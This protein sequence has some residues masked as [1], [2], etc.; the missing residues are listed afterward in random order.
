MSSKESNE[1]TN[2]TRAPEKTPSRYVQ[3]KHPKYQ[4]LCGKESEIQ[5]RRTLVGTASHLSLLSTIE[6]QNVNQDRKDECW[7]KAM[8]EELDQI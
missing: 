3:K 4:I 5:T 8:H 1:G 7:V 6:T 2:N